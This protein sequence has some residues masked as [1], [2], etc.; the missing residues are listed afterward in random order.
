MVAHSDHEDVD[1]TI[2]VGHNVYGI[3]FFCRN[4]KLEMIGV[5]SKSTHNNL[6]NIHRYVRVAFVHNVIPYTLMYTMISEGLEFAI[7]KCRDILTLSRKGHTC[8][9]PLN[10]KQV[11]S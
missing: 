6:R 7:D 3:K 8:V 4:S 1:V 2:K 5:V 10:S 11:L 9:R